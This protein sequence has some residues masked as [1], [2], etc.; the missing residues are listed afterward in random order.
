MC[1]GLRWLLQGLREGNEPSAPT[2]LRESFLGGR[3]RGP[4]GRPGAMRDCGW[5]KKEGSSQ[6][7]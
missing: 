3:V 1:V 7:A 4:A 2:E 6:V 5:R